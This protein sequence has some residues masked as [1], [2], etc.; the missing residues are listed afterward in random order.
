MTVES[1]FDFS[2]NRKI[3][4]ILIQ[5]CPLKETN[6]IKYTCFV[7]LPCKREDKDISCS[8]RVFQ[9][10]VIRGLLPLY[11]Y[12]FWEERERQQASH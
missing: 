6:E 9:A 4:I 11:V 10:L 12:V 8:K 7:N 2:F 1:A 5:N 3:L